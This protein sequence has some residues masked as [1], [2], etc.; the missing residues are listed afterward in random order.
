MD[1]KPLPQIAPSVVTRNAFTLLTLFIVLSGSST[2]CLFGPPDTFGDMQSRIDDLQF[3]PDT[4]LIGTRHNGLR[5]NFLAAGPPSIGQDYS[6]PWQE[7][8]TCKEISNLAPGGLDSI[9]GKHSD[10]RFEA[11]IP[12]GFRARLVNVWKYRLLV[13]ALSPELVAARIADVDCES[14]RANDSGVPHRYHI[15]CWVLPG[16]GLVRVDLRGKDGW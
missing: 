16:S 11:W 10:C 1:E 7:G 5:S 14:E 2:G 15:G 6:V 13:S 4:V 9:P 3:P 12:S 8:E